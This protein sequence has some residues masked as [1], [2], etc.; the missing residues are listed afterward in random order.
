MAYDRRTIRQLTTASEFELVEAS[1]AAA[2]RK[3]SAQALRANISRT[4]R[5]R[6]KQRDLHRRQRLARRER[7]GTKHGGAERTAQKAQIL[8]R[9][10][11]RFTKR[12]HQVE[13]KPRQARPKPVERTAGKGPKPRVRGAGRTSGQAAVLQEPR[14]PRM[15]AIQAHV[16]S[17][18]RRSQA[19]R[20]SR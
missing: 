18:G 13:A 12:L 6:D 20:D 10:L 14:T 15:K 2:V 8:D 16:S 11:V 5:L 4:R 19:R 9:T 7:T 1:S 3:L 17:R